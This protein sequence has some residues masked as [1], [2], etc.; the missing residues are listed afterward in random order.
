M[1]GFHGKKITDYKHIKPWGRNWEPRSKT[2]AAFIFVFGVVS[3]DNPWI[4][5]MA[6]AFVILGASM[7][8]LKLSF[9][10]S[11]L[12]LLAP[13]LFFMTVPLIVGQGFP[14]P[15][16]RVVFAS[17]IALKAMTSMATMIVMLSTQ[18]LEEFFDGLSNMKVP[19]L[20]ISVLFLSCRY[21]FLFMEEIKKTRRALASRSFNGGLSVEGLKVYGEVSA[22]MFVKSFDRSEFVYRAMASRGFQGE[23]PAGQ[24]QKVR[25]SDFMKSAITVFFV[26]V[27]VALERMM[28]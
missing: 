16:D 7:M 17:L 2:I 18:P 20:V 3:L 22:G 19:P 12:V 14:P 11:R 28:L 9:L 1:G 15:A 8:G 21:A 25:S 23:V 24:P 6:F 26:L 5:L 27:T 10:F 13:F 4:V